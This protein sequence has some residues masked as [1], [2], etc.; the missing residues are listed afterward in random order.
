MYVTT[1]VTGIACWADAS[2]TTFLVLTV[3]QKRRQTI[4]WKTTGHKKYL[5]RQPRAHFLKCS[6]FVGEV[7][8]VLAQL[9][10]IMSLSIEAAGKNSSH[11][12]KI[13][14]LC[15]LPFTVSFLPC[16]EK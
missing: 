15:W 7:G 2:L 1:S 6:V 10:S 5:E 4:C 8:L 12:V 16:V 9:P 13:C 11:D 14:E 3:K